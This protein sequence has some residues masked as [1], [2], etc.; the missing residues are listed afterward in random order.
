MFPDEIDK[1]APQWKPA[2]V[3]KTDERIVVRN[4]YL[5]NGTEVW[6]NYVVVYPRENPPTP[7]EPISKIGLPDVPEHWEPVS[8]I[9][10]WPTGPDLFEMAY[11]MMGEHGVVGVTCG[12]SIIV[13]TPEQVMEYY[14]NPGKVRNYARQVRADGVRRFENIMKMKIRPD[15]IS[16]GGSG[17]LVFQTPDMYRELGLPITKTITALCKKAGIFSH[18]HSCGP[19]KLLVEI[20]ANETDLDVIDP[21]E[22]PP[23][24]DCDLAQLK[25][26]FGEKIV[27]KGNLHTIDVMLHGSV[28]KVI[29]ESKRAIDE[30]GD[31]GR[32]ILSTGDQCGRDTP[33][34]NILAM[35]ETA[36]T[37]GRY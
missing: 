17:T 5:E 20:C 1:N 27:L 13:N 18:I 24:G 22:V 16:C 31:G 14:D 23:M 28:D 36:R 26:E 25:R 33:D 7:V 32:F 9:K 2:I 35:I 4:Y 37:Y 15:Y 29:E 19:E 10:E 11:G 30:A 8:G 21:L 12:T 3:E 34:E 6:E